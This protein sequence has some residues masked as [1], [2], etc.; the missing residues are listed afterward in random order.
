MMADPSLG[1]S[2]DT[3]LQLGVAGVFII[4]LLWDNREQRKSNKELRDENK[5]LQDQRAGDLKEALELVKDPLNQQTILMGQINDK[6]RI[7][8]REE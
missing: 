5:M 1:S 8:R 6:L 7:S 3:L 2:I 4:V